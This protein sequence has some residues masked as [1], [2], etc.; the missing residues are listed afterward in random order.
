[1]TN[2]LFKNK[3][4]LSVFLA[5]IV[6]VI[7]I[8]FYAS[9]LWTIID[10]NVQKRFY[11][12][13]ST[14]DDRIIVIKIDDNTELKSKLWRFPYDRKEYIPLIKNLNKA[15]AAVIWF[16]IIFA[17]NDKKNPLSDLEFAKT[18]KEAWNIVLWWWTIKKTELWFFEEPLDIFKSW[19]IN[20]WFFDVRPDSLTNTVFSVSP[21]KYFSNWNYEYFWISLLRAYYSKMFNNKDFLTAKPII[22][23]NSFNIMNKIIIPLSRTNSND[24]IINYNQSHAKSYSFY[25]VY[26]DENFIQKEEWKK[27]FLKDKIVIIWSTLRW[28]DILKTPIWDDYWVYVHANFLNTVFNKNY[29]K[30]FDKNLELLLILLIS[31]LAIYI[32]LAKSWKILIITNFCILFSI[33]IY[34]ILL[35]LLQLIP[36]FP[37]EF[38]FAILLSTVL[39]NITKYLIENTDKNKLNNALW[40]YVS[41]EVAEEILNETW[42]INLKWEKRKLTIFFSDI[43]WFTNLSEIFTPEKLIWFLKEYLSEMSKIIYSDEWRVNKYEWDAIMGIWWITRNNPKNLSLSAC[44]SALLQ[45]K[46]LSELNKIWLKQWIPNINIRIWINTWDAIIWSIWFKWEK[47]EFTAIWDNVNLASRLESINKFYSTNICVSESV[48]AETKDFFDFRYLDKI[49]V[50]WKNIAINIYELLGNKWTLDEK[51]KELYSNF[52][53]WI[54]FYLERDFKKA[55]T[56]F[57][58]LSDL[59]DAPSLVYKERCITFINNPPDENWDHTWTMT[60]K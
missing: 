2:K 47:Q 54:N 15:W 42:Y 12:I 50:K 56:I 23:D 1:M 10:K 36:N 8:I 60:E 27:D 11:N 16:D 30:Y 43:E 32:N 57:K 20:V 49:K 24:F 21:H 22:K 14:Y 19:A 51:Q 55:L 29:S 52:E 9:N 34:L 13:T 25:E 26:N 35:K 48:Y 28:L 18:I 45:I 38:I 4:F 39:S 33:L 44:N 53:K 6:F 58:K 31:I 46:K 37:F 7:I 3:N 41:K 40:E 5:L 17:D 59:W